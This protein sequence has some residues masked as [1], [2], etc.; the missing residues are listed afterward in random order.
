MDRNIRKYLG[1]VFIAILG[2][3]L[4]DKGDILVGIISYFVFGV[5]YS[6]SKYMDF[7]EVFSSTDRE[8]RRGQFLN[9]VLVCLLMGVVLEVVLGILNRFFVYMLGTNNM[10]LCL[11]LGGGV[12]VVDLLVRLFNVYLSFQKSDGFCKGIMRGYGYGSGILF[13]ILFIVLGTCR[14]KKI[15]ILFMPFMVMGIVMLF[16]MGM[17]IKWKGG[18]KLNKR[19]INKIGVLINE[20]FQRGLCK[21][22]I[23]GLCFMG[24][25]ILLGVLPLRYGYNRELVISNICTVYLFYLVF[26]G[27]FCSTS[28]YNKVGIRGFYMEFRRS[29]LLGAVFMFIMDAVIFV[30]Y[31]ESISFGMMGYLALLM[32]SIRCFWGIFWDSEYWYSDNAKRIRGISIL[33]GILLK[34]I[35]EVN[36]MGSFIR[37]G[38]SAIYGDIVSTVI[39]L[40]IGNILGL[41]YIVIR[42]RVSLNVLTINIINYLYECIVVCVI[43]T[44]IRMCIPLSSN[45][46]VVLLEIVLYMGIVVA[47]IGGRKWLVKIGKI[48]P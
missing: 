16:V 23:Y 14:A 42:E 32:V 22:Y 46:V 40:F 31:G 27:L 1:G 43:F 48:K 37:M 4:F 8:K 18:F 41:I 44:L 34:G 21:S 30:I 47:M 12:I 24:S 5:V 25:C 11:Y 45:R 35:L 2:F 20:C 15:A 36:L 29:L 17:K 10:G 38:Q 33:S 19:C 28:G 13:V 7:R 9:C 6:F 3:Y 39:A 26:A